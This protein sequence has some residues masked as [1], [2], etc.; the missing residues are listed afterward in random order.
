M[1]FD[2]ALTGYW[3]ARRRD[4]SENTV[5]DYERT[6]LRFQ[7][8]VGDE[9]ELEAIGA[10][11]VHGFLNQLRVE[12]LGAKSLANAWT[13]LSSFWS[14]AEAELGVPH[15]IRGRVR[16][17]KYRRQQVEPLTEDEVRRVLEAMRTNREWRSPRGK[18]ARNQRPS[19][20]RDQ[21]IVLVL[22]DTGIRASELCSLTIGDYDPQRGQL[23]IRRGKGGKRR[24]VFLGQRAQQALWRYL[25]GRRGASGYEP[26]FATSK[27]TALNRN[28]LR[29]L[30]AK[31]GERAGVPQVYPHRFRHTFAI[32]FLRNG[33]NP[34][35]LQRILGHERMDTVRLYA[36]LAAV[37]L[38]RAQ[39]TSSPADNW[40]L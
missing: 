14:W 34:L 30:L 23:L 24:T 39:Q 27:G 10:E 17:P 28:N 40:R 31:A 22:L 15:V 29:R 26:L 16:R 36:A 32:T 7:R 4:F 6:F 21:A 3:L 20:L 25:G 11:D 8:F 33:G 1:R 12:G 18:L 19:M 9:R 35:V 37:D 13:A 5:Q 38:E 2:V